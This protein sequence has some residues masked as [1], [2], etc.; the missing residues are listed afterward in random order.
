MITVVSVDA[1]QTKRIKKRLRRRFAAF[2]KNGWNKTEE[3]KAAALYK[4]RRFGLQ[5]V[6]KVLNTLIHIDSLEMSYI[7]VNKKAITNPSFT[8]APYGIAYNYF[9]GVLLSELIFLDKFYNTK[10]IYDVRNKETHEKRHFREHLETNILGA[11]LEKGIDIEFSIEGH[12]SSKWYG[13][14]AADFFSWSI[15]RKFEYGDERF[16]D[17]FRNRL[18]RRREWYIKK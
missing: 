11:A 7:A 14:L 3:I 2:I 8:R 13:L 10:V 12:D 17:R 15:F 9:T 5:A 6:I 18:R 16:Y 1:S 4:D